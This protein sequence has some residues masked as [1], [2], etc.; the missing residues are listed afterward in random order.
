M[1]PI[2]SAKAVGLRYVSD[3][4]PGIKRLKAGQGF[5][6]TDDSGKT[7]R[8]ASTLKRI[9]SLVVPPAWTDVWICSDEHGHPRPTIASTG[10][11]PRG[12]QK[13]FRPSGT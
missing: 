2:D 12:R 9:R 3:N 8:A 4:A 13:F 7:V 1:E 6:Y 5:R 11:V 10:R